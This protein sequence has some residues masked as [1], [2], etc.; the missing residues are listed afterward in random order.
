MAPGPNSIETEDNSSVPKR[1]PGT[2]PDRVKDVDIDK[3]GKQRQL[4]DFPDIV[5][6]N[7]GQ[8]HV[9]HH[10]TV[11]VTLPATAQVYDT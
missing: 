9:S 2:V 6:D 7:G 4:A 8:E 5:E 3:A 1:V 10:G 11:W